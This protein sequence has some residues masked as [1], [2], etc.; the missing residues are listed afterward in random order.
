MAAEVEP[1]IRRALVTKF[2][3]T[4]YYAPEGMRVWVLGVTHDKQDQAPLVER[5]KRWLEEH[6]VNS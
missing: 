3:H 6:R 5:F 1:G 4:I 2:Q